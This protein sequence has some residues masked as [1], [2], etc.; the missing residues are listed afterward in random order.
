MRNPD[1]YV[2]SL[3]GRISAL[4]ADVAALGATIGLSASAASRGGSA[5]SGISKDVLEL[6]LDAVSHAYPNSQALGFLR[7]T[8]NALDKS[9]PP[10]GGTRLRLVRVA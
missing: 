1:D 7:E 9:P 5:A 8:L 4:E 3:V 6:V 10:D 2:R